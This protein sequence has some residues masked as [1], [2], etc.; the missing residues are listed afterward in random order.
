MSSPA[1]VAPPP[2]PLTRRLLRPGERILLGLLAAVIIAC[3]TFAW[4]TRK[5]MG[6]LAF[7]KPEA[8]LQAN[9]GR[10]AIVNQN[11]WLTAQALAPLAVSA[12][13][14]D[15]AREAQRQA[16]HE[17]DQAFATALKVAGAQKKVFTPE[18]KAAGA[19]VQQL[20]PVVKD[21]QAQVA[22]LTASNAGD[23]EIE[24]AKA[25]LGLDT[26]NLADAQQDLARAVDDDSVRIQQELAAHEAVMKKYDAQKND[27]GE[28]AVISTRRNGSLSSRIGA[29]FDQRTRKALILQAEQ[30]AK[31]D[32]QTLT[33]EHNALEARADA[34]AGKT[35]PVDANG[36]L[37]SIKARAAQ[38]QLLTIYD[39]R[40][41]TEQQLAAVYAKW[42]AQ[43]AVQH[44]IVLHLILQSVALIAF[45][46][47]CVVVINALIGYWTERPTMDQR[48]QQTLRRI[49]QVTVQG[50]GVVT[51][52]IVIFGKP[53]QLS[54]I[55]GLATAGLTVA[56]Q[57]YILAF[58]G[59]FV[60]MGKN[61]IRVGDAVEIDGVG[62]EVAEIGLFRTLLMETGNW[63]AKGHPTGR[64]V[65]FMNTFAVT[66][67]YFN[68]STSGQWMWD[69]ITVTVP[70]SENTYKTIESIHAAVI[71]ETRDDAE[72]A[73]AELQGAGRHS[74]MS[75]Q[76]L[77]Q[78]TA[79]PTVNLR[80]AASGVDIVVRYVTRAASRFETRNTLY[81]TMLDEMQG[82]PPPNGAAD[83]QVKDTVVAA[84]GP[85]GNTRKIAP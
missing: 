71:K 27:A 26:D 14:K 33:A 84:V 30:E 68:F 43:V 38:R 77:S 22:A 8:T 78:F 82:T 63:T 61:G 39:D 40:I 28:L 29:W 3:L 79:E 57:S 64:R 67:K 85:G 32:V 75:A 13:E 83:V 18:A 59:W 80:P 35:G 6:H 45:L 12:E 56:L 58:C 62:G 25:Q 44:T 60:L 1:P 48:R 2:R 72:A 74:G 42:A 16:D 5:S 54:T 46:V 76:A 47:L 69:E 37:A 41:D 9:G 73:Q 50:I 49:L 4:A 10:S 36:R 31:N 66:G 55:L 20:L 17:V 24:V 23:D 81:Q 11:P 21:D 52:L 15:D 34:A 19:R 53:D 51:V 65:A 70:A 7:L